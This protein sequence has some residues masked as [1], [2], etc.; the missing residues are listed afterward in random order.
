MSQHMKAL[1]VRTAVAA[2][3]LLVGGGT[4]RA[5]DA[6]AS[7]SSR[8][9]RVQTDLGENRAR[10]IAERLE[11]AISLFNEFLHYDPDS[12]AAPLRVRIF[13]GKTDYD[14]YLSRL[15]AETR[16][17]FV[18]ISYS[19]PARGE[20]LGFDRAGAEFEASLLHYG[21][22]QFLSAYV[23]AAP[24]WL[25]EG[26]ATYLEYSVYD[27]TAAAYRFRLSYAWLDALKSILRDPQRRIG[28]SRLVVMDKADAQRHIEAFYPTAWGLVHFLLNSPDRRYNRVLWEAVAA[29][30]PAL[31]LA[32]NSRKVSERAFSWVESDRLEQ[33]FAEFTLGLTTFNDR[34]RQGVEEY[35]AGRLAEAE[36]SFR[37]ALGLRVDSY[38]PYYYL[39]LILYQKRA[40]AEAADQYR[41]AQSLGVEPA[42]VSY[43]LGVNAFAAQQYGEAVEFLQQAKAADPG[44]YGE[45]V[46]TLLGRIDALR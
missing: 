18:F 39:G 19:D 43:A 27:E 2:L 28:V 15:I 10:Q 29:L 1:C 44:A 42:L 11:A 6:Q 13:A 20:L 38:V 12:L 7:F 36:V 21:F 46:D 33:D 35:A 4:L 37:E 14:A 25:A 31:D 45:K 17:D 3:A 24:L 30:D 5:Q 32:Q 22:I 26:V 8:H 41:R 40:Y 16:E 9:Y 23:P 34:V